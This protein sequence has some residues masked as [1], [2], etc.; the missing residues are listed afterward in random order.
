MS[1]SEN[2]CSDSRTLLR[3]T[4]EVLL[5]VPHYLPDYSNI[6]YRRLPQL[7]TEWL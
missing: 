6:R 3:G 5:Y 1:I 7:F 2:P 4:D